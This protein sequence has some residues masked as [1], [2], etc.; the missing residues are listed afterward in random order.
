MQK[1]WL[2]LTI[3]LLLLITSCEP[4]VPTLAVSGL[5]GVTKPQPESLLEGVTGFSAKVHSA[6]TGQDFIL[7]FDSDNT[8]K[9][10]GVF[11]NKQNTWLWKTVGLRD[12]A[13]QI[14][15]EIGSGLEG[16]MFNMPEFYDI[17]NKDFNMVT[18]HTSFYWYGLEIKQGHLNYSNIDWHIARIKNSANNPDILIRGHPLVWYSAN[19]KW[20]DDGQFTRDEMITIMQ[21]H[22]TALVGKYAG[23]ITEWVVVNE[24]Y[25]DIDIYAKQIGPEYIDLAFQAARAANPS[26]VLIL[27]DVNNE[28][29]TTNTSGPTSTVTNGYAGENTQQTVEIISRLKNKGL[30]DGVGLQM[31]F[32]GANP[33]SRED[34][35]QTMQ[36]YGVPVYITELDVDLS[37][38]TGTQ[39][40]RFDLQ[41][42]VYGEIL[43]ACLDSGVCKSF[44]MWGIGDKYS[45]LERDFRRHDSDSTLYDNDLVPK[46]AYFTLLRILAKALGAEPEYNFP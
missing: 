38:V 18:I 7:G 45:W 43:E 20:F 11:D 44:T 40:E 17:L 5:E 21:D 39:Q 3:C 10:I 27:N 28:T 29:S 8:P 32:D 36:N 14:G 41:A 15:L 2:I 30:V 19:P 13:D 33:P 26:A 34:V 1:N 16:E 6:E 35:I 37:D 25:R 4:V 9:L 23:T 46:T 24:P 42:D 31:H 12:L 22:V